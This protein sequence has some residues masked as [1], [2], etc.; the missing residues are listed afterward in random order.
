MKTVL[1]QSKLSVGSVHVTATAARCAASRP[2]PSLGQ[3]VVSVEQL[4]RVGELTPL[5]ARRQL[6]HLVERVERLPGRPSSYL[7]VPPPD[8]KGLGAP[9]VAVWLD[10]YFQIRAQPHYLALLSAAA[11]HGTSS[12][13]APVAQALT[14][15]PMRPI[16][17]GTCT[18]TSM[19]SR[20]YR[21]HRFR[22][23]RRCQH[24]SL[25]ALPKL[26]HLTS[27]PSVIGLAVFVV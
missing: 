6:E 19:S 18:S 9:P 20:D 11:L 26:Q 10:A 2:I 8:H 7:L 4:A 12:Q 5:A 1:H 23:C 13:V 22:F 17:I 16:E 27:S 15:K 14:V 24:A 25:S 3:C 21:R